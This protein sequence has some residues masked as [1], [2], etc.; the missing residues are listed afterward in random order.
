MRT[1]GAAG[2]ESVRKGRGRRDLIQVTRYIGMVEPKRKW[3]E[4]FC[5]KGAKKGSG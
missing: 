1:R 4:P 5:L 2:G 3:L